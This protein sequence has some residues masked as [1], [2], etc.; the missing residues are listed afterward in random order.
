MA[1]TLDQM[2]NSTPLSV[3]NPPQ[4]V[5]V[6][7]PECSRTDSSC[8]WKA[9]QQTSSGDPMLRPLPKKGLSIAVNPPI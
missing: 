6:F 5:P 3:H 1:Q 7:V 8:A 2:R 4:R 9:F